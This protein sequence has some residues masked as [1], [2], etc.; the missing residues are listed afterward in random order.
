MAQAAQGGGG[1]TIPGGVQEPR[2][3]GTEGCG[4]WDGLVVGLR[5]GDLRGLFQ[6]KWFC[7]SITLEKKKPWFRNS[8]L[9]FFAIACWILNSFK[10]HLLIGVNFLVVRFSTQ[11]LPVSLCSLC[12]FTVTLNSELE[13][14]S[15]IAYG[16]NHNFSPWRTAYRNALLFTQSCFTVLRLRCMLQGSCSEASFSRKQA[17]RL[18]KADD[19]MLC[20]HR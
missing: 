3:C 1:V 12:N 16:V 15:F 14:G 8:E 6:P 19:L 5:V 7:D 13:I 11:G 20:F 2:I 18:K 10:V 17:Y 9:I 4:Q